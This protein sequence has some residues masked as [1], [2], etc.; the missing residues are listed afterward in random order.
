MMQ[1]TGI[2][3]QNRR[4]T[5]VVSKRVD[6]EVSQETNKLITVVTCIEPP[7]AEVLDKILSHCGLSRSSAA[8]APPGDA[9]RDGM[10]AAHELTYVEMDTFLATF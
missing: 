4:Q 3:R 9:H 6:Y 10:D 5:K 1:P 2:G 7:Q 8:R